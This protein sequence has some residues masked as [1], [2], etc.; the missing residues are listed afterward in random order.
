MK[1]FLDDLELDIPP[2]LC[3]TICERA[4]AAAMSPSDWILR[5]MG[6]EAAKA[7]F[8]GADAPRIGDSL[9]A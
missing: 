8:V 6:R 5:V 1:V 3:R 7:G 2:K 4:S 9:F